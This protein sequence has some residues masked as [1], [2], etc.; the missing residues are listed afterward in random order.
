MTAI[1]DST[2]PAPTTVA[3]PGALRA[4]VDTHRDAPD[5]NRSERI[6]FRMYV[7][8]GTF[9]AAVPVAAALTAIVS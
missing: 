7:A 6:G 8:M 2:A 4:V 9:C 3:L 5:M 1:A